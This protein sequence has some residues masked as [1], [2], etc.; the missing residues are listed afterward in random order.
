MKQSL[1]LL[2]LCAVAAAAADL[3]GKWSGSF[4]AEAADHSIP[5]LII[6]KQQGSALS[7]SAGPNAG[8]QY[9]LENARV[10]GNN[11][12]FEVTTGEWRFTYNLTAETNS[13]SGD[14]KLESPTQSRNAKVTLI[15]VKEQ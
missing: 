12:H 8:E 14:L 1:A 13:L 9:P 2:L 11:V 4:K 6:V 15:R 3:T 7:G 10:N 5:Q